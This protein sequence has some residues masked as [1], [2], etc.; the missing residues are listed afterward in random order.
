[1]EEGVPQLFDDAI[2]EGWVWSLGA[3]AIAATVMGIFICGICILGLNPWGAMIMGPLVSFLTFI[4]V[5]FC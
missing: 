1:M 2:E 4:L 3:P 5:Y